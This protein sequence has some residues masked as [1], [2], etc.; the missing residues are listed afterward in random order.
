MDHSEYWPYGL[1]EIFTIVCKCCFETFSCVSTTMR[2]DATTSVSIVLICIDI[3]TVTLPTAPT[4]ASFSNPIW[5]YHNKIANISEQQTQIVIECCQ[6]F[7]DEQT[8]HSA[9]WKT[10]TESIYVTFA[11]QHTKQDKIKVRHNY[12]TCIQSGA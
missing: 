4:L 8:N 9:I 12:K 2:N 6:T 3:S 1:G 5:K 11:I 10:M 7:K